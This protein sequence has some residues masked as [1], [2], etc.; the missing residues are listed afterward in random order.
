AAAARYQ[1]SWESLQTHPDP[2]WFEDAKFGIYCHWGVYSVP[3]FGTE[4]YSRNMYRPDRI[5]HKH[6]LEKYGTLDKFGYK[7][8]IPMF[9]AEHF[10]PEEWAELFAQAGAKFAGPVTEH[11]D[12][13][14]MWD[15]RVNKWNAARMGPKRDV[16]GEL[17]RAIRKRNMKFLATFHHQWLWAWYPTF[18]AN[19]DASNS[20]YSGLYGPRVSEAAWNYRKDQLTPDVTFCNVW[21]DKVKEVV[22]R[23]Q[24]DLIYFD[25]RLGNIAEPYR[26]DL[27]AYYYNRA[28]DWK[29]EV[30]LTYKGRDLERGAGILDVERG[31][32]ASLMPFKWMVDD[33]IDWKSW[34]Y[35]EDASLKS[36]GRIVGELVDVVSKNGNL[37]LNITPRAD[38][39]IPGPVQERLRDIGGWLKLNG[40]AIYGTR[41]WK[42]F[43]EGPTEVKEGMFGEKNIK[44]LT[45][46]DIRFTTRGSVLHAV[47]LGW[48]ER[49]VRIQ[50]LGTAAGMLSAKITNVRLIG[51]DEKLQWERGGEAFV[52]RRP[53]HQ[54]C[55]HA[56]VFRI[57]TT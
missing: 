48:P 24:P 49:D 55:E 18:D 1:P 12:G 50:S 5:E 51:S 37:L 15:S 6:H 52:I 45:A 32:M 3:A 39:T 22:D 56:I 26:K 17:A 2:P 54:P 41:P 28:L 40:E 43:G 47:V 19:V 35:V 29:R 13:F 14:S 36:A 11:A 8:F 21:R 34:C 30:G 9:R 7:D 42:N 25:S 20:E 27:L 10:D 33:S 46:D 38:G 31:R 16:V 23:Y 44:D 4:W 53:R 57:E